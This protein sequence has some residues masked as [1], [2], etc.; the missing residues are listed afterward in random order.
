[1]SGGAW[2]WFKVCLAC[3]C[4]LHLGLIRKSPR[5]RL[6]RFVQKRSLHWM[7]QQERCPGVP[8]SVRNAVAEQHPTW[9]SPYIPVYVTDVATGAQ[10]QIYMH[11]LNGRF[12]RDA[13][14]LTQPPP[15]GTDFFD[16]FEATVQHCVPCPWHCHKHE[17]V[18]RD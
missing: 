5:C 18:A 15:G 10:Q 8:T 17:I 12:Q 16:L 3:D 9:H 2:C 14:V 13:P 7:L 1:M 4:L 11:R 6:Q